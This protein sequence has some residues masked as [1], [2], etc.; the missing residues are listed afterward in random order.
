MV[1]IHDEMR[2]QKR[3][4]TYENVAFDKILHRVKVIGAEHN[5]KLGFSQLCLKV[6]DQLY[7]KIRY[8]LEH[9][10]HNKFLDL[11]R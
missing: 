6:I 5:I 8:I 7:D 1:G 10:Q 4:G 9:F 11:M 2:V 3:N